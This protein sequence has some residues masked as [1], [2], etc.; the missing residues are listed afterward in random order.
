MRTIPASVITALSTQTQ[1]PALTLTLQDQQT[2]YSVLANRGGAGGRSS[3]I[4]TAA[5]SILRA[6]LSQGADPNT[7]VINRITSPT[8]ATQWT[9]AGV[10]I[11]TGAA[12]QAGCALAQTGSTIRCFYQRAA[13][14]LIC[15]RDSGDDGQTWAAEVAIPGIPAGTCSLCWGLAATTITSILQACSVYATLGTAC[16]F[17][18]A[19][20]S[21][22]A[23]SAW[24]SIATEGPS[25]PSLWWL[26]GLCAYPLNGTDRIAFGAQSPNP[27]NGVSAMYMQYTQGQSPAYNLTQTIQILDNPNLGLTTAWPTIHFDSIN[28]RFLYI[29]QLTDTGS[30]SG[31]PLT[32][33]R[34]FT[35]PDFL[36]WYPVADFENM[37]QYETH[38]LSVGSSLFVFDGNTTVILAQSSAL[39]DVSQDV[40]SLHLATAL[41]TEAHLTLTLSNNQGQYNTQPSIRTDST[42][43]LGVGYGTTAVTI[44]TY[45]IDSY[46]YGSSATDR[47]LVLQCRDK[48]K[49]L[50]YPSARMLAYSGQTITQLI[51][52]I[53]GQ[54]GLPVGT[55]P[56]TPQF[57]QALP[58][59]MINQGETWLQALERLASVYGF[60]FWCDETPKLRVIDPQPSD[61]STWTYGAE[62]LNVAQSWSADQPNVIRVVGV[63]A[64]GAAVFVQATDSAAALT[65]GRERYRHVVERQLDTAVRCA[66]RAGI[67]LRDEQ[68]AAYAASLLVAIN[69]QHE[70]GDVVTFS[71][72]GL[73]GAA[74]ATGAGRITHFVMLVEPDK[75]FFEQTLE[76][77][78][79]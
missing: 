47:T 14:K 3:A 64:N 53:C 75:G 29:A 33:T 70:L 17:S 51:T 73:T 45:L 44:G 27:Y 16:S 43:T 58:C 49:L 36:S 62:A 71:D 9:A 68:M 26:R 41:N 31:T 13:D 57:G 50:D 23:W 12:A 15:Y 65:V 42:L 19:T 37:F 39:V 67:E 18:R 56:G 5:S 74:I 24:S 66:I 72:P 79:V 69:P 76:M 59:F 38:A 1:Q 52:A 20:Y 46:A 48:L 6:I 32:R 4:I 22:G 21:G 7:L 11:S 28:F 61:A 25:S 30:V 40:L 2:R 8:G 54:A 55:L 60:R 63:D 35:T 78:G 34:V 77:S 10:T